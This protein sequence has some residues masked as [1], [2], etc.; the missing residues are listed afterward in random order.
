MRTD[1]E[2]DD[3]TICT[4]EFCNPAKGCVYTSLEF[5]EDGNACTKDDF[6]LFDVCISGPPP[7]C[8]DG[9]QCTTDACDVAKGCIHQSQADGTP[10]TDGN[11]CTVNDACKD[12]KCVFGPKECDYAVTSA[13][14]NGPGTLRAALVAA[15]GTATQPPS[16]TAQT[17]G[18][19]ISG[20]VKPKSNLPLLHQPVVIDGRDKTVVIDGGTKYAL[21]MSYQSL[22]LRKLKLYNAYRA[23]ITN[24]DHIGATVSVVYKGASSGQALLIED[25]TIYGASSKFIGSAIFLQGGKATLR[26]SLISLNASEDAGSDQA[27]GG[28]I[29]VL[30]GLDGS[31]KPALPAG[32]TVENT[33]FEYNTGPAYGGTMF[34]GPLSLCT[35]SRSSFYANKSYKGCLATA[36]GG[37]AKLDNVSFHANEGFDQ[38]G[39]IHSLG[40]LTLLHVTVSVSNN[41][42]IK[43]NAAVYV[44]GPFSF[45]NSVISGNGQLQDGLDCARGANGTFEVDVNTTVTHEP[46]FGIGSWPRKCTG[47]GFLHQVTGPTAGMDAGKPYYP[48]D[49]SLTQMN[50]GRLPLTWPVWDGADL[51][52]CLKAGA[53]MRGLARPQGWGCDRGALESE[54]K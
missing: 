46:F 5:C 16:K 21:F 29:T 45:M 30:A 48:V 9:N 18:F 41:I 17:I 26:R 44:D 8:D 37:E 22:T 38:G 2:C 24:G 43:K 34:C 20:V 1:V 39:T 11:T 32:L 19:F 10:C 7:D 23:A 25:T 35:V 50:W 15:A 36:K 52:W 42:D 13:A 28:A 33:R 47:G 40:K 6:C 14:D 4:T 54:E 49:P 31:S 53:D 12:V 3:A 51:T 27:G